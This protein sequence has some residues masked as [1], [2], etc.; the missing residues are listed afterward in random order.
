[1]DFGL[2]LDELSSAFEQKD[3]PKEESTSKESFMNGEEY[4]EKKKR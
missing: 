4:E 3:Q 2:D 1:M